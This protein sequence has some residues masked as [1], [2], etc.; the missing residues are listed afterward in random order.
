MTE[1]S[2]TFTRIF[3]TTPERLFDA[4]MVRDHWQQWIGPEGVPC[5]VIEMTPKV[6]ESYLLHMSPPDM[7]M[8]RVTGTYKVINRPRK[9]EFTWESADGSTWS[10]VVLE[11][12]P[13]EGGT[14]LTLT[15]HALATPENC[16]SHR[17]GWQSAFNKLEKL[18]S[19]D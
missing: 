2:L 14:Q 5:E 17:R 10:Y 15:H 1:G 3:P 13:A 9:I 18:V 11:F 6:G 8:I 7:G 19:G 12:Q 16:E 4:W